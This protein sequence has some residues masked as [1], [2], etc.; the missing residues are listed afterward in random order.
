MRLSWLW[1]TIITISA[2]AVS[3]VTFVI[4]DTP[5]RPII[6]FWFLFVCPG[7]IVVR[8]LRLN[9]PVTEWTL[10]LA[11]SFSIDAII[12]G[13]LLYAGRWSPTVILIILIGL[14]L[15]GAFV[16]FALLLKGNIHV[17][18]MMGRSSTTMLRQ[19]AVQGDRL[20]THPEVAK[21]YSGTIHHI[22]TGKIINILLTDIEQQKENIKGR[23]VKISTSGPLKGRPEDASFRGGVNTTNQIQ[24]IVTTH[25]GQPLFSFDGL[26]Q[27]DG[28]IA[29]THCSYEQSTGKWSNYG[30][31]SVSPGLNQTLQYGYQ[32]LFKN[33]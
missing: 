12:A 26:I 33:A 10:A 20:S 7:M 6:V 32:S 17:F 29:G 31:W 2:I 28:S 14:C 23:F 16:Q 1:A 13:I 22:S 8:F 24:L 30:S 3:L 21:V 18:P 11:L 25:T 15:G 5:L 19:G 4:P 27:P 9:E